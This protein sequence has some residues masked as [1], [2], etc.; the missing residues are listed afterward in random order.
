MV[1]RQTGGVQQPINR[2]DAS[3]G[4]LDCEEGRR[5]LVDVVIRRPLQKSSISEV[6]G[7]AAEPPVS[8]VTPQRRDPAAEFEV[9]EAVRLALRS[10]LR[11]AWVVEDPTAL[12]F[13]EGL[14]R[15]I[16]TAHPGLAKKAED[17]L[18]T[19]TS[20][21]DDAQK[22]WSKVPEEPELEKEL[23][24]PLTTILGG[25]VQKFVTDSYDADPGEIPLTREV[26]QTC[27]AYLLQD[28]LDPPEYATLKCSPDIS[29]LGTGP[30]ATRK[31]QISTPATYDDMTTPIEIQL[32]DTFA[33]RVKDQVS[34][35]AREVFLYQNNRRFVY[36]PVMTGKTIR[37]VHFDR[38]GVQVSQ[39]INY[40]DQPVFFVQLVVLFSSLNEELVGFDTSIYWKDGKRMMKMIPDEIWVQNGAD[41]P[42]WNANDENFPLEFEIVDRD[43]RPSE[44]PEP[45]FERRTIRSRGTICWRVQY[46]GRQLLVKDYWG[47][48]SRPLESN[49][50]KDVAMIKGIGQLYA[51]Q[52]NR[53]STYG[54]RGLS[55]DAWLHSDIDSSCLVPNRILTRLVLR[56]YGSTL[57]RASSGLQLLRA[58]RDIVCGHRDVFLAKKILHRDISFDN[59]LLA[60]GVEDGV[61]IDFDMAKTLAEIMDKAKGDSRTGTRAY[62]S[63][64]VLRLDPK[65]GHHDHMD[66][67]ESMFYVL[68]EV[69][70]GHGEDGNVLP[71]V[72]PD[73][74]KWFVHIR[75][76]FLADV[77]TCFLRDPFMM[78]MSRFPQDQA[79]NILE[80]L[81]DQLRLFFGKRLDTIYNALRAR[82]PIP[83]PPFSADAASED[84]A[85]F[86]GLIE[87]AIQSLEQLSVVSPPLPSPILTALEHRHDSEKEPTTPR[88]ERRS[89][90]TA[91]EAEHG[92]LIDFDMAKRWDVSNSDSRTGTRAYQSVKVLL[93]DPK[94]GQHD[95][96]DDLES[97]YYV[98]FHVCYGH[99]LDGNNLPVLPH[100]I[101]SW[102]STE[103]PEVLADIK[104]SFLTWEITL[105]MTRFPETEK[106]VLEP[107]IDQL[108]EFFR[109]RLEAI[110][111]AR[112]ARNPIP[113]PPYSPAAA[114]DD[115]SEFLGIIENAIRTLEVVPAVLKPP[116]LT[117][118]TGFKRPRGS[119][120]EL[121]TP[122]KKQHRRAPGENR[123]LGT[124]TIMCSGVV[125]NI[126]TV[127]D[128]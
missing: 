88:M 16:N 14:K 49:F 35:Y 117:A 124:E 24:S 113:Y 100:D 87:N 1:V 15:K 32:H 59:L 33:G 18:A 68:V 37:V 30:S 108:R 95:H 114:A 122:R 78:V 65:L 69:C 96:M 127:Q 112:R 53:D 98:L 118:S 70:F 94:L 84:Y 92:V 75:P 66:D 120:E 19:R 111:A 23:Y 128:T 42:A 109:K 12:P 116:N 28:D 27:H 52:N 10:E 11:Q 97:I 99:D 29:I 110:G 40:H 101:R 38:S 46:E 102:L 93:Q 64:K 62:Q 58:V 79:E 123:S 89:S 77:K 47:V 51:F 76:G 67:L 21:Y 43:G 2:A 5:Y 20:G 57:N 36:V 61:L 106:V 31:K 119:E 63:V 74:R 9:A 13:Q 25:I 73:I 26:R 3:V 104:C 22:C 71:V 44:D 6:S 54:L 60:S 121:G 48:A 34:V 39:P 105:D 17:W 115:Y 125:D 86:I 45:L 82:N 107:L 83:S 50:L 126:P 81:M 55:A 91:G 80:P 85:K 4:A 41:G 56:I 103:N 8:D 72:P 7:S 90:A